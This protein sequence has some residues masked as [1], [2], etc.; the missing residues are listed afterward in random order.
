MSSRIGQSSEIVSNVGIQ[1]EIESG[2][3]AEGGGGDAAEPVRIKV[4]GV[5][6][7]KFPIPEQAAISTKDNPHSIQISP[8]YT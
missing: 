6:K 3:E 1:S 5:H 4:A 7:L 2:G 8:T